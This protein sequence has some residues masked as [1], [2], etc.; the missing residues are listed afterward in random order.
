M[1]LLKYNR[2]WEKG[3]KY[4]Y[5]RK[6][7]IFNELLKHIEERQIVEVVGLRRT[8]KTTLLFQ[9][10][11]YL[12]EKG[13][14]PFSLCYFTFDE[15]MSTIDGLLETFSHQTQMDF[16]NEKVYIFLDE[17]QKLTDFQNQLKIYYDLYPNLKFFISGSTSLFIKKKTQESLAGRIISFFLPPLNFKEYLHF[18]EKEEILE[19][20]SVFGQEIEKEF[21]MFLE[22]QFI[23]TINMKESAARKEYLIS[24]IR[25]IIFEDIPRNFSVSNPE[26]L[27]RIVQIVGQNPG[28]TIDYQGLSREIGISNKTLSAYFFYLAE[29]FLMKKIFNFSRN[30]LT[31][32]KK[33]KKFYLASPSF[34]AAISDFI[35]R[36][37]LVENFVISL[38]DYR[39]FWRDAYKHEVDF[40]SVEDKKI[41]PVEV[42]YKEKVSEKELKN[43]FIFSKRF[44]PLKIILLSKILE[45]SRIKLKNIEI[46]QKPIYFI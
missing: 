34:S 2:H 17:I 29:S 37:K 44:K 14:N 40:I 12:L 8:G 36:G 38:K 19:K 46:D 42:K 15:E 25:K 7:E 10:I 41:I 33:L 39:F 30:L 23:E 45:E 9:I 26:I 20:L 16:K 1:V 28:I 4:P 31:S 11:N 27:W 3:F 18:K 35:E 43:L 13:A 24:V 5:T 32:E 22:S 21:E 6:R